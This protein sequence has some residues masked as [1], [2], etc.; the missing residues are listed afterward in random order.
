MTS[1]A[2]EGLQRF[3]AGAAAVG[4]G[5]SRGFPVVLSLWKPFCRIASH[6]PSQEGPHPRGAPPAMAFEADPLLRLNPSLPYTPYCSPVPAISIP[7]PLPPSPTYP[8]QG[9]SA[10]SRVAVQGRNGGPQRPRSASRATSIVGEYIRRNLCDPHTPRSPSSGAHRGA[11]SRAPTPQASAP[12]TRAAVYTPKQQQHQPRAQIQRP[13]TPAGRLAT[14]RVSPSP[15]GE[16]QGRG[17]PSGAPQGSST[18]K[19]LAD[20]LTRNQQELAKLNSSLRQRLSLH[21]GPQAKRHVDTASRGGPLERGSP[22]R[23]ARSAETPVSREASLGP[24]SKGLGAPTGASRTVSSRGPQPGRAPALLRGGLRASTGASRGP[25]GG[26][27]DE[28]SEEERGRFMLALEE[29]ERQFGERLASCAAVLPR[30]M[31]MKVTANPKP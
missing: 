19:A 20:A 6:W 25:R 27:T 30:E 16:A 8:R 4:Q 13:T 23:R 3:I 10:A 22:T 18:V 2:F 5:A 1:P 17:A 24:R 28:I 14:R 11:P 12:R 15:G 26:V 29:V 31:S 9:P 7:I 21:E